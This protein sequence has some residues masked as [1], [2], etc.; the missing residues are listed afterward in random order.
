[1]AKKNNKPANKPVNNPAVKAQNKKTAENNKK[2]AEAVA[3]KKVKAAAEE[4]VKKA[5]DTAAKATENA[6]ND[7]KKNLDVHFENTDFAKSIDKTAAP[8]ILT[9]RE[10]RKKNKKKLSFTQ[11]VLLS[12]VGIILLCIGIYILYYIT[13]YTMY[14]E[15]KQYLTDYSYE[16]GKAYAPLPNSGEVSGFD[17]VAE[18]E[19]LKL[20]TDTNTGYVAVYDKRDGKITY[21][22]PLDADADTKA[23]KNNKSYMKAQM[24]VFYYNQDVKSGSYDSF[25]NSI[26]KKQYSYESIENGVRYLYTIGNLKKRDG[27][28]DIH[29]DI[30]LEYRLKGDSLEVSIPTKEIKEYG[31]GSVYRIQLLKFMGAAKDDENGYMVVPNASGSIIN[32]NNGKTTAGTY[33]QYV[34]DVDPLAM[35]FTTQENVTGC[36][37]PIM[38]ICREDRS[39]LMSVE[40]GASTTVLTAGISGVLNQYNYC[41]PTFILRNADNLS[42]FGDSK[43]DVFVL[44]SDIYDINCTVRYSF[45]NKDM[46]GYEGIANYYRQRLINDGVLVKQASKGS[47]PLYYDLLTGVKGVS[48]FIGVQYLKTM[49]MTD[50]EQAG[51]ISDELAKDGINNQVVNLQGWF[52]GGYYHDAA[53]DIDVLSK[54]GGESGIRELQKKVQANG[55]SLFGDVA[56]QKVSFADDDFNYDAEGSRYYGAGYVATAGLVN[57]TTLYNQSSLMYTEIMHNYLSPKFLPRY[58]EGFVDDVKDISIDGISLRDLGDVLVSDKRRTEVINREE[59]LSIVKSQFDRLASTGKKLLTNQANMYAWKYSSDIINV[60]I[61]DN[62]YYLVDEAI[63]L[64]EMILHG[65][66]SYGSTLLNFEDSTHMDQTALKLIETGTAPH[67]VFTWEESSKMKDTAMSRYYATT[68]SVWKDDAVNIYNKVNAALKHVEGSFITGHKILDNKIRKISYDN[69]IT[70]YVNYSD[71]ELIADDGQPVGALSY[72]LEG[73]N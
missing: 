35:G 72:R 27:S 8:V 23:N 51:K 52:N 28:E 12:I 59:A 13:H 20:F 32:F 57:P 73:V 10:K 63:P 48:H 39:L 25:T 21:S 60:P 18:S 61:T 50:F 38:G 68:F 6:A 17:L 44:E 70:I 31:N 41:F 66:V 3:E 64:Y 22:N 26:S 46:T 47:I 58:V 19:S 29:F 49:S 71:K 7:T 1:M 5:S 11:K 4:T 53:D 45:L 15:Y 30:P 24:Q 65:C 42:N 62:N 34:Y 2:A 69:G 9:G 67:F 56:L 14:D 16:S 40:D 33:Q 54:L 36:K 37:L 43:Q 55:G